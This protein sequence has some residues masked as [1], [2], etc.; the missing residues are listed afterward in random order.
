MP[1]PKAVVLRNTLRLY[2]LTP[3]RMK[4]LIEKNNITNSDELVKFMCEKQGMVMSD[5]RAQYILV[6]K[7]YLYPIR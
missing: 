3:F 1:I 4:K 2:D 6:N 7:E 5:Q